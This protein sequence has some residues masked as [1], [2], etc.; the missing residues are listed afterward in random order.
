MIYWE[1][2]QPVFILLLFRS[3]DQ[4]HVIFSYSRE[5]WLFSILCRVLQ[6]P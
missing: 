1:K 6:A 4:N 5:N 2:H 3:L